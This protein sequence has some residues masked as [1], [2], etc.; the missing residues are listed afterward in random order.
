MSTNANE[1]AEMHNQPNKKLDEML[2][3]LNASLTA[4][5]K[6]NADFVGELD[7]LGMRIDEYESVLASFEPKMITTTN[8][9]SNHDVE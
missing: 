1:M 4:F 2:V 6:E 9:T 3:G 5:E 8:T 7:L